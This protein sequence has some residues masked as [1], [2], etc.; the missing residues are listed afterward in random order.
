MS[1][2]STFASLFFNLVLSIFQPLESIC[3]TLDS[4]LNVENNCGAFSPTPEDFPEAFAEECPC[5]GI[6]IADDLFVVQAA[7]MYRLICESRIQ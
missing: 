6:S 7:F 1:I 4:V 3:L 5:D 2:L